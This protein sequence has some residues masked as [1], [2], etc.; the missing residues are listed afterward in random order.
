[1]RR[2]KR[3]ETSRELEEFNALTGQMNEMKATQE[4]KVAERTDDLAKTT[5]EL[6]HVKTRVEQLE[7]NI[8]EQEFTLE[9]AARMEKENVGLQES[10]DQIDE[11]CNEQQKVLKEYQEKTEEA[12][13]GIRDQVASYNESLDT[14]GPEVGDRF[15]N[16]SA[17]MTDACLSEATPN[18][19]G[20]DLGNDANPTIESVASEHKS[21]L[22]ESK[23]RFQ[24][25]LDLKNEREHTRSACET[26]CV[27]LREK[28]ANCQQS[29]ATMKHDHELQIQ[30]RQQEIDALEAKAKDQS[31]PSELVKE[32][33]AIERRCAELEAS[34]VDLAHLQ[35]NEQ[36]ALLRKFDESCRLIEGHEA[37]LQQQ[38]DEVNA[39]W[40]ETLDNVSGWQLKD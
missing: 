37:Y 38:I 34:R 26:E 2:A 28:V 14:I 1:M 4:R 13:H 36:Q 11:R 9:D 40:E 21:L 19:L 22:D 15:T 29:I 24:D 39:L 27:L 5:V 3:D 6:E 20:V 12:V 25:L 8:K 32:L 30:A 10:L 35:H 31:D 17:Q 18:F 23:A 7:Q 33:A 16:L